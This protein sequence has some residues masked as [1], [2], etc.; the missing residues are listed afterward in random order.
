MNDESDLTEET[1]D[2]FLFAWAC[3]FELAI[4]LVGLVIA[5]I[6]GMDARAYIGKLDQLDWRSVLFDGA[7]GAVAAIPMLIA[8]AL[9][10]KIPHDS[11]TAIK[12]LSD[13]PTIKAL[14]SLTN[15]EL[16]TLSLC[17][18]IGEELAFRGVLLPWLT[19]LR[20]ASAAFPNTFDVGDSFQL[21]NPALLVAAVIL[22]SVAFGMVHPIT[23]LYV[24]V[25][26]TMGVYFAILM[27]ATDSLIVPMVCHAVYDA[28]QFMIAKRELQEEVG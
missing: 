21:A 9:L 1:P 24:V 16:L 13:M 7:L 17:A 14:L 23:K 20:D 27:I 5:W 10:M 15:A 11:I 28:A 12:R 3:G 18:G 22:S 4:G 2:D 8:I 26:S 6:V 25:A 19:S